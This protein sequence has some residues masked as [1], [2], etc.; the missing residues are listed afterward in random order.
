MRTG[1]IIL[2][3]A[4]VVIL[5][6]MAYAAIDSA[7]VRRSIANLSAHMV[8]PGADGNITIGDRRHL[9]KAY[10]GL[11]TESSSS[12]GLTAGTN[13]LAGPYLRRRRR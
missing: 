6:S 12:T 9:A 5:A 3:A 8:L 11:V 10:R 13:N 7:N 1:I 4:T 2:A